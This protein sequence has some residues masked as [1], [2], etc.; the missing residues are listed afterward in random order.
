M[1]KKL[2][3]S[4]AVTIYR[5]FISYFSP[6]HF[7]EDSFLQIPTIFETYFSEIEQ[8]QSS[9][10]SCLFHF[11][12]IILITKNL[13]IQAIEEVYRAEIADSMFFR[14]ERQQTKLVYFGYIVQWKHE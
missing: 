4:P 10:D 5:T 12:L 1:V 8:S 6:S 9:L 2:E 7:E 14:K 13:T 11:S 3:I